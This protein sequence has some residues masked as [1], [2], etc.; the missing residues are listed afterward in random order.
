MVNKESFHS[1]S[2]INSLLGGSSEYD[3]SF[4]IGQWPLAAPITLQWQVS[5]E[6]SSSPSPASSSPTSL[7]L[8]MEA[9]TKTFADAHWLHAISAFIY[10]FLFFSFIFLT[11]IP[12][13]SFFQANIAKSFMGFSTD[14]SSA[15]RV[16]DVAS[17]TNNDKST[18]AMKQTA[19]QCFSRR[20]Y[21]ALCDSEPSRPLMNRMNGAFRIC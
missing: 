11:E 10:L 21:P 12:F 15:L 8:L 19:A 7:L 1:H 16:C 2:R 6:S 13:F 17:S 20:L 5:L 4:P 9:R 14:V 3:L 18:K